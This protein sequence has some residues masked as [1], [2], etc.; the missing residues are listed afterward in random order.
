M[1][2]FNITNNDGKEYLTRRVFRSCCD[3]VKSEAAFVQEWR[4]A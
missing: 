1:V 4:V 2:N 3:L